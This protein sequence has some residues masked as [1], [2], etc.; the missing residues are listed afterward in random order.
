MYN[1]TFIKKDCRYAERIDHIEG[2]G[3][4]HQYVCELRHHNNCDFCKDYSPIP[5]K[6][7]TNVEEMRKEFI[8]STSVEH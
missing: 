8:T 2:P 5:Q 3:S 6:Y 7:S 1:D 4:W